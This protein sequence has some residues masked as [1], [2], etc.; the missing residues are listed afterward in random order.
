VIH[1]GAK[2]NPLP[3]TAIAI[4]HDATLLLRE[5]KRVLGTVQRTMVSRQQ[6]HSSPKTTPQ[7]TEFGLKE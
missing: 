7:V 5:S 4:V 3:S 2:H 1:C 6:R